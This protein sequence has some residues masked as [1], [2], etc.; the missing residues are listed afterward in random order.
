[1]KR[2]LLFSTLMLVAILVFG[3]GRARADEIT[4]GGTTASNTP[5]GITFTAGSFNGTTSAGF[6][7]FSNLG[8]YTLS[9]SAGNYNG[10]VVDLT[11]TFSV[12]TG[13]N[14]GS[15]TLFVANL[16]GNVNTNAQGG[17]SIVF[18]NPTQSFSFSNSGGSGSFSFTVNPVALNPGGTTALSGFV[19]GGSIIPASE[20]SGVLLL[21]AGLLLVPFLGLRKLA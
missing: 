6:A 14:G 5:A 4:V 13:I 9:S 3:V 8:S 10:S 1:L 17:V 18:T 2:T 12:P 19:S 21:G 20:P 16:F 15:S 11:V 7:G